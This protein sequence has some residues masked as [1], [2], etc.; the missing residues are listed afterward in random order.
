MMNREFE[1]NSDRNY[2]LGL[3]TVKQENQPQLE[4]EKDSGATFTFH[5]DTNSV[6]S[7]LNS[8]RNQDYNKQNRSGF[9]VNWNK[10][11]KTQGHSHEPIKI[12]NRQIKHV[13]EQLSRKRDRSKS[14]SSRES[15]PSGERSSSPTKNK[16]DFKKTSSQVTF[17]GS[18]N[19]NLNPFR[20]NSVSSK[21]EN[22]QMD[23]IKV[24][25]PKS[26]IYR[27][28]GN[29]LYLTILSHIPYSI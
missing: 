27:P 16:T 5:N 3:F 21:S 28:K 15:S 22:P 19:A 12:A 24:E 23:F 10:N 18:K 14:I 6:K 13:T 26:G 4:S 1:N 25:E 9:R 11:A 17:Q 20:G 29:Y 7:S 8:F 2:R